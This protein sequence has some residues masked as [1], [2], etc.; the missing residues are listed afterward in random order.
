[1]AQR[2]RISDAQR[3]ILEIFYERGMVGTGTMYKEMVQNA[4][5]DTGLTKAQVQA[6]K[7]YFFDEQL[8]DA[9][10]FACCFIFISQNLR[11]TGSEFVPG[12]LFI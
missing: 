10:C 5:T 9:V 11:F 6:S 12:C 4:A 3:G 2:T 7:I 8:I 1:M